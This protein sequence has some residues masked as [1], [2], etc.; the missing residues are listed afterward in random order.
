M[1]YL[2]YEEIVFHDR[3]EIVVD[4]GI[5]KHN[6]LYSAK[7]SIKHRSERNACDVR[8]IDRVDAEFHDTETHRSWHVYM[9]GLSKRDYRYERT[10]AFLRR[11]GA[12]S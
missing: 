4:S 1:I 7:N 8:K 5:E 12:L 3:C 9:I 11:Y 10:D 2:G 6:D